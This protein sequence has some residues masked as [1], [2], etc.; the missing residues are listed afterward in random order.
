[1][2]QV[3]SR[4]TALA[5]VLAMAGVPVLAG[6]SGSNTARLGL[7]DAN[8]ARQSVTLS[9]APE[10]GAVIGGV[11]NFASELYRVSADQNW[12]ASPLS[13]DLAF[14]MLRAGSRGTTAAE[15]DRIF[16]YPATTDPQGSPHS[17]LNALTRQLITTGPVAVGAAKGNPIVAIANG[18]FIQQSFG[19]HVQQSYLST[20]ASQYGAQPRTVDFTK[21]AAAAAINSWVSTQ[22]RKRI[23]KL[24]DSIDAATVLVLA[25]A[26]YL[27]AT[28]ESQFDKSKSG[29]AGFTT[30]SAEKVTAQFMRQIIEDVGYTASPGWQRIVL[31]YVGG[32]LTMRIV[33]PV[34]HSTDALL[35]VATEP[36]LPSAR[37]WVDL[38]LPKWNAVSTIDLLPALAR[39]GL[40]DVEDLDGIAPGLQVS[41]AVHRAM[42]TVDE[43]GTEAAAVT[44]IAIASAGM[45]G[46]PTVMNVDR[47]FVWAIVH[48]PTGTPIF[49]GQ[50][51]D[52]TI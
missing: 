52:P 48:E 30:A 24:F 26:V 6:C 20:L 38:R 5:A 12:T 4:R 39:L 28:W 7:L 33:L 50:V 13:I 2:D 43:L 27:K 31:P 1:M 18:L 16:G 14:A 21:P 11:R 22:T 3:I 36:T 45:A 47:P 8:V 29:P 37:S 40:S 35:P 42:I 19:A 23:A 32:E 46:S 41:Q 17:A 9:D 51:S 15:L 25:N 34:G 49:T 44:G 10:L